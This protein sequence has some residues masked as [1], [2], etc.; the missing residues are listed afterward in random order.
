M[1]GVMLVC[2]VVVTVDVDVDVDVVVVACIMTR[3][4]L[5]S[6]TILIYPCIAISYLMHQ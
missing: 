3:V 4:I 2:L 1:E 5:L 6:N